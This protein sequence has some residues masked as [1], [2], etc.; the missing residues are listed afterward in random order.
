MILVIL[1]L[2][3]VYGLLMLI[4]QL[5]KKW[6]RSND[7]TLPTVI[8]MV[9]QAQDWIEWFIRQLTIQIYADG[10]EFRDF[11][12]VDISSSEETATIISKLESRHHF[13][14]Y[15]ASSQ[16]RCWTD[17]VTLL[18]SGQQAPTV[19]A[20]VKSEQDVKILLDMLQRFRF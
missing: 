14:T 9:G 10:Q 6:G 4:W 12:I 17:V 5:Q 11:F 18:Q 8:V 1:V 13:V 3:A 7:P 2:L 15:V 16:E 20:D 19:V